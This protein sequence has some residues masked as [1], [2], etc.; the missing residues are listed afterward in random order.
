MIHTLVNAWYRENNPFITFNPKKIIHTRRLKDLTK[1]SFLILWGGEDIATE[2]YNESPSKYGS[3][4]KKSIRDCLEIDMF[5]KACDLEI[6]ILGICRG[7]QLITA[8]TGGSLVQHI[9]DHE[10]INHTVTTEDGTIM[11]TN[12]YHHQMMQP[13]AGNPI[14]AYGP[15]TQGVDNNDNFITYEKVPEMVHF[16]AVKGLGIQGHIE[17]ASMPHQYRLYIEQNIQELLLNNE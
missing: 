4:E 10:G 1:N 12:S 17:W 5:N 15:S 7:A 16:P 8:L 14:L 9:V 6:P 3:T 11:T 2:I 13:A